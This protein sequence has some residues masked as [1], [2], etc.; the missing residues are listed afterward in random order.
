MFSLLGDDRPF[1][2]CLGFPLRHVPCSS[3]LNI[4]DANV[5]S[6]VSVSFDEKFAVDPMRLIPFTMQVSYQFMYFRPHNFFSSV[7]LIW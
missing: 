2:L 6:L 4:G 1:S 3:T 7:V 5:D